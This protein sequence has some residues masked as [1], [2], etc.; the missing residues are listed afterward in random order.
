MDAHSKSA[1]ASPIASSPT[2]DTTPSR[3]QASGPM[4]SASLQAELLED[5]GD[6]SLDQL[7]QDCRQLVKKTAEMAIDLGRR[8]V[9]IK[10][11][12]NHGQW[13]P[14]LGRI[15]INARS[16]QRMMSVAIRFG[17]LGGCPL[18]ILAAGSPSKMFE[19][20]AIDDAE[21]IA[22]ESGEAIRSGLTRENLRGLTVKEVRAALA[23]AARESAENRRSLDL[24][25]TNTRPAFPP[26][27]APIVSSKPDGA[28]HS[29]ASTADPD[30]FRSLSRAEAP[31]PA[32][33]PTVYALLP[34]A[35]SGELVSLVHHAG[36]HWMILEE[37]ARIISDSP[38]DEADMKEIADLCF[39][40]NGFPEGSYTT[41]RLASTP[42]VLRL[43]DQSA[44]RYLWA[45]VG[46]DVAQELSDWL[47]TLGTPDEEPEAPAPIA[48]T[49][50]G[51]TLKESMDQLQKTNN[52]VF[53][54]MSLVGA[55]VKSIGRALDQLDQDGPATQAYYLAEIASKIISPFYD[56]ADKQ[57]SALLALNRRLFV[58]PEPGARACLSPPG[59][60]WSPSFPPTVT[61]TPARTWPAWQRWP[62]A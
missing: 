42:V 5:F 52:E 44:I 40:D 55:Q 61:A 15:G 46:R 7:E 38:Q 29:E 37:V 19:L 49:D 36:K 54:L 18:L 50:P 20:L 2:R 47:G 3:G 26:A 57:D 17:N 25:L 4:P 1:I 28:G 35:F 11:R 34:I 23:P 39:T 56:L 12:V 14:A 10:E 33:L 41:V 13:L 16:A 60:I 43:V 24:A 48:N 32:T 22:L 58:N 27:A 6:V 31:Q 53:I 9:A 21:I 59:W 51:M 45:T 8:L 30:T 62:T